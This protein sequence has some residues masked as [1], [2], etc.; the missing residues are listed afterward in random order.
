MKLG[1]FTRSQGTYAI[2]SSNYGGE[3]NP[4]EYTQGHINGVNGMA[5]AGLDMAGT[6]L[7]QQGLMGSKR[8]T[9]AGAGEGAA[10][11]AMI[12]FQM[13]G[14]WGAVIGAAAGFGAGIGEKIA[15]VK[16][17]E[18]TAH[19]DVKS[20][21]GVDIPP[22][23][24]VIK[25]IVSLAKSQYGGSISVAVRSPNVRQLVM[26]YSEA[27]G[28]KMPL[29]ATTPYAGSLVEQGG[30]LYQQATYLDG[31]AHTYASNLPTLGGLP[32]TQY[33]SPTYISMNISGSDAANFMTGQ[34]VTPQF[35]ADQAMAAQYSS[36]ARTQQ[37]ANMQLP[38][39]TVA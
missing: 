1:G 29:S 16:S 6:A 34:F 30:K 11:G 24:G 3:D 27:S 8:G 32:T 22:N 4:S 15:G 21:Y 17:D 18:Q 31:Q 36:Y 7:I 5:G 9:W 19:D 39:L 33:P 37:A 23:T 14:P 25:Q 26:L 35:V 38:G 12:G 28:Q 10:G 13:G 2:D 20:A